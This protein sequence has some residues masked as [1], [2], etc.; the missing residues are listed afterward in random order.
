M[1]GETPNAKTPSEVPSIDDR[2]PDEQGG[3]ISR[4]GFTY[5]DFIAIQLLLEMIVDETMIRIECETAD[6]I[7]IV[8][9]NGDAANRSAEFVQVKTTTED[10]L[11]SCARLCG[12]TNAPLGES[13]YEKSLS[14]ANV[15]EDVFFRLVTSQSVNSALKPLTYPLGNDARALSNEKMTS[16]KK[17][18]DTRCPSFCS[19]NKKY[20]SKEWLEKTLWIE[21]PPLK[22]VEKEILLD[23][24]KMSQENGDPIFYEQAKKILLELVSWVRKAGDAKWVPDKNLKI[25][26]RE[27]AVIWWNQRIQEERDGAKV[28]SGGK[29]RSKMT[30]DVASADMLENALELRRQYAKEVREPKYMQ[31]KTIEGLSLGVRAKLMTLKTQ[32]YT[33]V[34]NDS[35]KDFHRRCTEEVQ[36]IVT[37][38][39]EATSD[40]NAIGLGC[41]YDI[42]DRCQH[43]F[44]RE[45]E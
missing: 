35:P 3:P 32:L 29:L 41:M 15:K 38:H 6:D 31:G 8:R 42:T 39:S 1:T 11:W 2:V 28:L 21:A 12:S 43:T 9:Q 20:T 7:V 44:K 19:D 16:L 5:Q 34:I 18:I 22:S 10:S 30:S 26:N 36:V 27:D 4:S 17:D 40:L 23:M 14:N 33:N 25:I 45:D 24:M 13:I 37:Q